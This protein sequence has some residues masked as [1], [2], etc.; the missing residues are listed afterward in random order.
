M[1]QTVIVYTGATVLSAICFAVY[2]RIIYDTAEI[3]TIL[4]ESGSVIKMNKTR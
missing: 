3:L 2:A 1:F 4:D